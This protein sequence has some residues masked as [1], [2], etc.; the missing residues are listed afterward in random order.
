MALLRLFLETIADREQPKKDLW[1]H[2][3]RARQDLKTYLE[4][5]YSD[6]TIQPRTAIWKSLTSFD[7]S[8]FQKLW[9]RLKTFLHESGQKMLIFVTSPASIIHQG[10]FK[11]IDE[12]SLH[13]KKL[14]GEKVCQRTSCIIY[15]NSINNVAKYINFFYFR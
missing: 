7:R 15:I 6:C 3:I 8:E 1:A 10:F 5:D 13:Q 14:S 12:N 4:R 11:K 2:C 9:K